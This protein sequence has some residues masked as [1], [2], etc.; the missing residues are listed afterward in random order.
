MA[1][2]TTLRPPLFPPAIFGRKDSINR[3]LTHEQCLTM[4]PCIAHYGARS[5]I[6]VQAGCA[7]SIC[8]APPPRA[9]PLLRNRLPAENVVEIDVIRVTDGLEDDG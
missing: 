7:I 5:A 2:A 8:I 4:F 3:R 9:E 1:M 6:S